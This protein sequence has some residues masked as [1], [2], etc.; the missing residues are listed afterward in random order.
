[1]KMR[2]FLFFILVFF[3]GFKTFKFQDYKLDFS[4]F[5]YPKIDCVTTGL[6]TKVYRIFYPLDILPV[7]VNFVNFDRNEQILLECL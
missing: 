1:M 5:F 4:E 2:K 6:F 7:K 3:Y